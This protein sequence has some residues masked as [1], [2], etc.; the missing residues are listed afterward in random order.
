MKISY[1]Y[2]FKSRQYVCERRQFY[3]MQNKINEI[4]SDFNFEQL[5]DPNI[6]F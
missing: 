5:N 3:L 2:F 4:I 6:N 1:V